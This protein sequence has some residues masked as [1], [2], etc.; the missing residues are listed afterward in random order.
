MP[1]PREP[2]CLSMG[3]EFV[4]FAKYMSSWELE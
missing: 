4:H 3:V 1:P 2:L